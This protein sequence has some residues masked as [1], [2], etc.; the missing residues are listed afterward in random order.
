MRRQTFRRNLHVA[1]SIENALKVLIWNLDFASSTT[2]AT[3]IAAAAA[4]AHS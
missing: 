4:R 3:T 2:T 1:N